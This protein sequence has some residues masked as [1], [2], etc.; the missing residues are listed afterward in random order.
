MITTPDLLPYD[1]LV[2]FKLQDPKKNN[3]MRER[4]ATL[5][6]GVHGTQFQLGR[7]A[8]QGQWKIFYEVHVSINSFSKLSHYFALWASDFLSII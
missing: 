4:N 2:N 7:Y 6:Q 1:G 8:T 5:T 3:I